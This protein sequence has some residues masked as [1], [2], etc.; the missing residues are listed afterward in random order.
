MP[1]DKPYK[2]AWLALCVLPSSRL[3]REQHPQGKRPKELRQAPATIFEGGRGLFC[4]FV[5]SG[6]FLQIWPFIQ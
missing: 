4:F 6:V 1:A 3:A 5:L 2:R